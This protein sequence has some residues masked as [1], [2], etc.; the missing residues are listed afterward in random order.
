MKR[1]KYRILQEGGNPQGPISFLNSYFESPEFKKRF[2]LD[3]N[4]SNLN[5]NINY[6]LALN[7]F[8]QARNDYKPYVDTINYNLYGDNNRSKIAHD[9]GSQTNRGT[10]NDIK[11]FNEYYWLPKGTNIILNSNDEDNIKKQHIDDSTWNHRWDNPNKKIDWKPIQ[12]DVFTPKQRQYYMLNDIVPHEYGHLSRELSSDEKKKI[13]SLNTEPSSKEDKDEHDMRP[14]EQYSDLQSLRWNLYKEGI[15]DTRKGDLDLKTLQKGL[16]N[17]NIRNTPGIMR[18]LDH[19]TPQNLV[20]FNNEIASNNKTSNNYGKYGGIMKKKSKYQIGGQPINPLVTSKKKVVPGEPSKFT[21]NIADPEDQDVYN[22]TKSYINSPKYAQRLASSGYR[23]P[24]AAQTERT[25]QLNKIGFTGTSGITGYDPTSNTIN[26]NPDQLNKVGTT[27]GVAAAHELGHVSNGNYNFNYPYLRMNPTEERY[28]L[29]REQRVP[30]DR[31]LQYEQDYSEDLNHKTNI[32][33]ALQRGAHDSAPDENLSDIQAYRYLLNKKGLYDARTQ[34][35]TPDIIEKSKNDP[36][37]KNDPIMQ[38]LFNNFKTDD[39]SKIMNRVAYNKSGQN[40]GY[41]QN[42]GNLN[43]AQANQDIPMLQNP[44]YNAR[45]IML[46]KQQPPQYQAPNAWN[47]IDKMGSAVEGLANTISYIGQGV[48]DRKIDRDY[49]KQYQESLRGKPQFNPNQQGTNNIPIINKNGGDMMQVFDYPYKKGKYYQKGGR[50]GKYTV[51]TDGMGTDLVI[52]QKSK[53]QRGGSVEYPVLV[54]PRSGPDWYNPSGNMDIWGFEQGGINYNRAD[55]IGSFFPPQYFMDGGAIDY[56][57]SI[58]L[59]GTYK[60]G[61]NVS[62]AKAKE[63]LRDGTAQGHP[64]TPAQKRYF[65]WIAGGSKPKAE[66]GG[67]P[68]PD[69]FYFPKQNGGWNNKWISEA[70]GVDGIYG[71]GGWTDFNEAT[72]LDAIFCLG[73]ANDY[74]QSI[75]LDG[76]Y[77]NGGYIRKVSRPGNSPIDDYNFSQ[78]MDGLYANGGYIRPVTRPGNSAI[79]DY[80]FSQGMDGLYKTGGIHINPVNKGKF[81]A[82][83]DKSGKAVQAFASQVLAHPENYSSKTVHQAAFAKNAKTKF[84]H[85]N[86]GWNFIDAY[87]NTINPVMSKDR[88]HLNGPAYTRLIDAHQNGG[89]NVGDQLD[90]TPEEIESLQAQGYDFQMLDNPYSIK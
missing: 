89:Y 23:Y 58:G 77:A 41:A 70:T 52:P 6:P 15:Y 90:L 39:L 34:D 73:G 13:I 7:K 9:H 3:D 37:I 18:L 43:Y 82:K 68:I 55:T 51:I 26:V 19:F 24:Q 88:A 48:N 12:G 22:W 60:Q 38:R 63:I 45:P 67:I 56:D 74:D 8:E 5:N 29:D 46:Q 57:L 49:N 25:D 86:G 81:T 35:I 79:D 21:N 65:G 14:D 72:G 28:I 1:R 31:K 50:A 66:H 53:K 84:K 54:N 42:G 4:L 69:N 47:Y 32:S 71:N 27:R 30:E 16:Q 36:S 83:A 61:G 17:E 59:D 2:H 40:N 44:S 20:K 80:N 75:G 62:S 78:G 85:Q 76:M 11:A 33:A 64:L 87:R 10:A